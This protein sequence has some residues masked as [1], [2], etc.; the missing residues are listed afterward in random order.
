MKKKYL[1]FSIPILILLLGIIV[2]STIENSNKIETKVYEEASS[3]SPDVKISNEYQFLDSASDI[4]SSLTRVTGFLPNE[5]YLEY[6]KVKDTQFSY[7]KLNKNQRHIIGTI[8]FENKLKE[9]MKVQSFFMQGNKVA[10]VKVNSSSEWSNSI[11]YDLQPESSVE[12]SVKIEWDKE[13]MNELLF[14]PLEHTGFRGMYSGHTSSI[15]RNFVMDSETKID[16]NNLD[17]QAFELAPQN[18]ENLNLNLK[19]TWIEKNKQDVEL[20][21]NNGTLVTKTPIEGMKLDPV[22]YSTEVDIVLLDEKGDSSILMEKVKV[23]KNKPTYIYFDSPI[24]KEL[25]TST[26]RN[27]LII[28]NNREEQL[29]LDLKAFDLGLKPFPTSVKSVIEFYKESN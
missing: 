10:R 2:Y 21:V 25:R 9:N 17:N 28:L 4:P 29:L 8:V 7:I 13:G 15:H 19:P 26:E 5:E 27:F 20:M 11:L 12:I 24:L 6:I 16:K 1:S 23:E 22:P 3:D 14:F 18:Y